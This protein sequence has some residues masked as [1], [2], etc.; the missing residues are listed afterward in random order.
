VLSRA[1]VLV[2]LLVPLGARAEGLRRPQKLTVSLADDLLG[3]LAP[4]GRHVYFLSNRDATSQVFVQDLKQ[5]GAKLLFDE[6]ADVSFPRVS[7]D[8]KRLAYVS[9]RDDA[10][11]RLC[12]REL[13]TLERRCLDGEAGALEAAWTG[14]DELLL[15]SRPTLDG[16]LRVARVGV[17]RSLR[18]G[19]AFSRNLTGPAVSSDGRWLAFVPVERRGPRLGTTFSGQ[20]ARELAFRRLDDGSERRVSLPLAGATGQ[21]AFSP[22]GRWLYVTQFP[23]DTDQNGVL[24]ADDH[25]VVFRVPWGGDPAHLAEAVPQQISS[26]GWSCQYPAPARDQLILTCSR[27]DTLD[28]Y[29]L[30]LDGIVPEDLGAARLHDE[31]EATRDPWQRVLLTQRL[32]RSERDPAARTRL[33]LEVLRLHLQNGEYAS[34]RESARELAARGG[35]SAAMARVL[36]LLIAERL[37]LRAF[38]RGELDQRFLDDAQQ[39]LA[40]LAKDGPDESPAVRTLRQL[41]VSEIE[42]D[43]GDKPAAMRALERA[44][45]DDRALA[46]VVELRARRAERLHR[47]LDRPDLLEAALRPLIEHPS[48]PEPERLRLAGVYARA[49]VR[50]LSAGE[51][52]AAAERELARVPHG[53]LIAFRLGLERC[54]PKVTHKTLAA[55]TACVDALYAKHP[56]LARRR[57]LVGEVLR[58]AEATD[59]DDLEYALVHRW[60][61]DL[62]KES[63]ERSHAERRFRTVVEDYAYAAL[64]AGR[65]LDAAKEFGEVA[66]RVDSLESHVGYIEASLEA[67][68]HDV[69]KTYLERFPADAPVVHFVRAY[70]AVR[71]LP[72]LQ[73]EASDRAMAAALDDIEAAEQTMVQK[74]ELQALH[75]AVLHQR[76]L[77]KRAR[78]DAE[79]ANTHYLL[80]LDLAHDNARY[81]SM[82]LEHLALLHEAVGNHRIAIGH[83]EDREALPFAD[84]RVALGHQIMLSRALLHVGR[85]ADAASEAEEGLTLVEKTTALARFL[86]L[87]LDRA[88]LYRLAAGEGKAAGTHYEREAP[89]FAHAGDHDRNRVV[90]RL[91]RAAAALS[92]GEPALA[93]RELDAVGGA[94]TDE[95]TRTALG[96]AWPGVAP[97]EVT[98]TYELLRLGVRGQAERALGRLT[99]AD[100]SFAE[101]EKLLA[102]RYQR[103]AFDDDRLALSRL[104]AQR[105]E[106]AYAQH[107]AQDAARFAAD[108]LS[109]ADAWAQKTATP[110][111]DAQ[112]SALTLAAELVVRGGVQS[113]DFSFDLAA[114]LRDAF[115][116][117]ASTRNPARTH[118]RRRFGIYLTLLG[119]D[120]ASKK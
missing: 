24:D 49:V 70:L 106:L 9:F 102:A 101:R 62:P 108:A 46:F 75:G 112:L 63:A 84:P 105:A 59:A 66:R 82:I 77:R 31:I 36:E 38:D 53:S 52:D 72:D 51:A 3:Q 114:R 14:N 81:R 17:G 50:G 44:T 90:F 12:V 87:T 83:F 23:H 92:A 120:T 111:A 91:A 54:L 61:D 2:A 18:A 58:R 93:L 73:G 5:P 1:F 78:A 76:F 107:H 27:G 118:I 79:E 45:V 20:A 119:L 67:G 69:V 10:T 74:P 4:D 29:S 40:A 117:L 85:D 64:V 115:D 99:A 98:A 42:D 60:I 80:A 96:T 65:P 55:G 97:E 34:A 30:P 39:R 89:L 15:V 110:L 116:H 32:E 6:G 22:D 13:P 57:V 7:P 88:A 109:H 35:E 28:L 86:P 33:T 56:S 43:I 26:A 68:R 21:P 48:L 37:A 71:A 41:A 103:H 47:E 100:H 95:K 104:A 16:D 94:I 8:G 25:G 19:A 11:G 113:R